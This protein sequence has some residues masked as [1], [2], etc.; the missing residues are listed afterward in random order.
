MNWQHF[1]CVFGKQ[2]NFIQLFDIFHLSVCPSCSFLVSQACVNNI[3]QA[4]RSFTQDNTSLGQQLILPSRSPPLFV[5]NSQH[6]P[7]AIISKPSFLSESPSKSFTSQKSPNI[8]ASSSHPHFD[9]APHTTA[10]ADNHPP[11]NADT[12]MAAWCIPF[13]TFYAFG[14]LAAVTMTWAAAKCSKRPL[15]P[16]AAFCKDN[17]S[18]PMYQLVLY[19]PSLLW[20]AVLADGIL[21]LLGCGV[22]H[23]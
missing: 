16:P 4:S 18:G 12:E 23:L 22:L 20:L 6:L 15:W 17:R 21:W 3:P 9:M 2:S 10:I 1:Y 8:S 19:L 7:V 5:N 11:S 13:L 14:V